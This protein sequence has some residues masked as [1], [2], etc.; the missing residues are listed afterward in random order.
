MIRFAETSDLIARAGDAPRFRSD[1]V[2]Y[3][4]IEEL[5]RAAAGRAPARFDRPPWRFVVVVERERE[6]LTY[7]SQLALPPRESSGSRIPHL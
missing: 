6:Q 7:L 1:P 2:P 5:L 4:L 3:A